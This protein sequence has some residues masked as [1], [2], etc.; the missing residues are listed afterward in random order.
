M[1]K[2]LIA[3][4]SFALI[5]LSPAPAKAVYGGTLA[6]GDQRVL[7]Y[8]NGEGSNGPGCTGTM[9]SPQVVVTVAHCMGYNG[10]F[11]PNEVNY[12]S[13]MWVALPGVDIHS[14][15]FS[16]RVRVMEVLLTAGYD[17]TWDPA[18]GNTNTTIN[19]VAFL[20]LD[21]PLVDS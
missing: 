15:D 16:T 11:F 6:L 2:L 12:P 4:L 10:E 8:F 18:H 13:D 7:T 19:D 21:K 9:I 17:N 14:D 1:K 20:L 3:I 5:I